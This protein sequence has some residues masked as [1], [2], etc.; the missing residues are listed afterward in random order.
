[1]GIQDLSKTCKTKAPGA[2]SEVHISTFAKRKIAVDTSYFMV[3]YKTAMGE[4]WLTGFVTLVGLM[5]RYNVHPV[6][7]YDGV[8]TK[9]KDDERA[10]RRNIRD[11]MEL[12][13]STVEEAL[14]HLEITGEID[15]V[16]K[17]FQASRTKK[18]APVKSV[19]EPL[20]LYP[21]APTDS[22]PEAVDSAV[23]QPSESA[24]EVAPPLDLTLIRDELAKLKRQAPI[25]TSTDF[26][27][28]RELFQVLK[29]PVLQ[30]LFEAET[31]C[32]DLCKRGQVA[33]ALSPDSDLLAYGCPVMLSK[34]DCK[35]GVCTQVEYAKIL[36]EMG[37]TPQL[38]LDYCVMLGCDYNSRI[39]GVGPVTALALL[40]THGSIEAVLAAGPPPPKKSRSSA[41]AA[42]ASSAASAAEETDAQPYG[43]C[44][45]HV[46][47]REMFADYERLGYVK[48]VAVPWCGVP[49]IPTILAFTS[50]HG[51]RLSEGYFRSIYEP[52]V[53]VEVV[54]G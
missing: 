27:R 28:T 41:S 39:P 1:M 21:D 6:F 40:K 31:L 15:D 51:L 5:R 24:V 29:V 25:I 45:N 16:L 2:Y 35:T 42:S 8:A 43:A 9:D 37:M 38:F 13:A 14:N 54:E 12:K 32:A 7:V 18:G 34:I 36:D 19:L 10:R 46:R 49:D 47:I 20:D 44:L 3:C 52:K 17:E 30:A 22:T 50:A 33:A 23:E 53:V 26:D 48:P 4:Q 11:Q